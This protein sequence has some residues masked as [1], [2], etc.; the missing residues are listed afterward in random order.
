MTAGPGSAGIPVLDLGAYRSG[1]PAAAAALARTLHIA[2]VEVGFYFVTGHGVAWEL[3]RS[4]FAQAR[5]FHA[6]PQARKAALPVT[7]QITGYVGLGSGTTR[8]TGLYDG[9]AANQVAA[10]LCKREEEGLNHWPE[11]LPGFRPTMLAYMAELDR[12]GQLLLPLY[13]MALG[14]PRGWLQPHF[15][16]ADMHV[17]LAWYPPLPR[18]TASAD[19]EAFG[20]APHTDN[21]FLT[22]LPQNTQ[23]GLWIRP[24]GSDWLEAPDLPGSFLINTGDAL[25]R[26]SGDR[27][28]STEH[29]VRNETGRE[30][31]AIPLFY[32]PRGDTLLDGWPGGPDDRAGRRHAPVTYGA[33]TQWFSDRTYWGDDSPMP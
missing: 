26:W 1:D 13:D 5:R 12:L 17:R 23:P 30:R 21:A 22:F 14:L 8:T 16:P 29:L 15:A 20:V 11:G 32:G 27:V 31:V 9:T 6:L 24:D 3:V 28:L 18:G 25:R 33:Y 4:M 7:R 10:F 19:G 2:L